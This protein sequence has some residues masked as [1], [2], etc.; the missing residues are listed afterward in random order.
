MSQLLK[1]IYYGVAVEVDLHLGILYLTW[2]FP[3]ECGCAVAAVGVDWVVAEEPHVA[4]Q[5]AAPQTKPQQQR[6]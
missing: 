2:S 1:R 6:Q 4:P 5:Q 3:V